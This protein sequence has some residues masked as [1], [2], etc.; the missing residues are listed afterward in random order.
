LIQLP[1]AILSV[2]PWQPRFDPSYPRLS[3]GEN[4]D[5]VLTFASEASALC[6]TRMGAQPSIPTE[7][8]VLVFLKENKINF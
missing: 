7:K 3:K 1:L 6:V 4:W 2:V 8:K 5:D